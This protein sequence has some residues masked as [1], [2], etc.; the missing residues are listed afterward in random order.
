ML[1]LEAEAR[2]AL[3]Q[4]L[5]EAVETYTT[6]VAAAP[7]AP[8]LDVEAVRGEVAAFDFARPIDPLAALGFAVDGLRKHQVHVAHP[9]YFG[10]FNPAPTTMGV[11]ADT[12]VAAFNP[13]LAAWSHSPLAA[14]IEQHLVRAFGE[15][16]G[17]DPARVEG[18]FTSGGAEANHTALLTALTR[19]FPEVARRGLLRPAQPAA[20]L[21]LAGGAPLLPQGGAPLRA[22]HG[23]GARG[24]GRLPAADDARRIWRRGSRG[25]GGGAR[26]LSGRRDRRLH[27]RRAVDPLAEIA[28]IADEERLWLHVDAAWGGAAALVPEL[29]PVL[30]GI[31]RASSIT[32]DAHKWLS[33]PMGAGLFLTR[34]AGILERTFRVSTGYMPRDGGGPAPWWIPTR[35]RCSGRAASSASRSSSRWR[36]RA[37]RGTRT[38]IRHQTA[39][40]D[41]LRAGCR[42]RAGRSSTTRRC[43]WSASSTPARD[44]SAPAAFLGGGARRRSGVGG[45]LAQHGGAGRGGRGPARLHH[46]RPDGAADID[47]LVATLGR[48]RERVENRA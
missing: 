32:F 18:T 36:W 48:A 10:L 42:R 16:F 28:Q 20:D 9:R 22:R 29:R 34:H 38:A 8:P 7:V 30:Q 13:Q 37:G 26:A 3:W 21:R 19:A 27:R 45:G 11:A 41:R 6:D 23:G 15:R 4:R 14:E 47:A 25:P 24:A 43:R 17:Y 12:L 39:M 44:R 5:V 2:R 40:G 31:E 35:T 1:I 33:V 46:Q